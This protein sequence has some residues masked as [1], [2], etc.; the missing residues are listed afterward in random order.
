EVWEL[1]NPSTVASASGII[2]SECGREI[3]WLNSTVVNLAVAKLY[4]YGV[5]LK[6]RQEFF[7][8]G[9]LFPIKDAILG[10]KSEDLKARSMHR[11]LLLNLKP[12]V[13]FAVNPQLLAHPKL[14][15]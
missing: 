2:L 4:D 14:S 3:S 1:K 10:G 7:F 12:T 9:M 13:N 5:L 15:L 11:K 8:Q 6:N